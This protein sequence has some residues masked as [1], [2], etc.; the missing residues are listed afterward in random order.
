MTNDLTADANFTV[1]IITGLAFPIK[2]AGT[3][4]YVGADIRPM[5]RASIKNAAINDIMGFIDSLSDDSAAAPA[6]MNVYHGL[7]IALDAGV[8]WEAGPFRAGLALRDIGAKFAYKNTPADEF[9]AFLG[10]NSALPAEGEASTVLLEDSYTIP[11]SLRLG[12]AFHPDLGALK[13][14]IDPMVHVE[15]RETFYTEE[16]STEANQSFFTKLHAGA[17]VKLLSFL[18]LRGGLYQGYLTA[19]AGIKLLFLDVNVAYFSQEKG[20]VTGAKRSSGLTAE[21]ALRF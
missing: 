12:L 7:G 19:G 17:E 16:D 11:M 9:A 6:G 5:I 15:Y 3:T 10:T 18:K 8:I 13:S 4:L 21:V 2:L 14:L 20:I 1:A